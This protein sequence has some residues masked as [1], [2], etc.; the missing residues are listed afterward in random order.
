MATGKTWCRDAFDNF[1]RAGARRSHAQS[2]TAAPPASD[3]SREI[4]SGAQ[5]LAPLVVQS[6]GGGPVKTKESG[7]VSVMTTL[8][9][10]SPEAAS[11]VKV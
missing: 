5:Q 3:L 7:I 4:N 2:S 10:V 6:A 9:T 1:L 11:A 8:V